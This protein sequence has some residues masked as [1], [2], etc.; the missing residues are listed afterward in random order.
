[1]GKNPALGRAIRERVRGARRAVRAAAARAKRGGEQQVSVV[2]R[3]NIVARV[4]TGAEGEVSIATGQQDSPLTQ[5]PE[6]ATTPKDPR[7]GI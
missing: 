4:H 3:A 7:F 6:G 5:G 1:M 2:G